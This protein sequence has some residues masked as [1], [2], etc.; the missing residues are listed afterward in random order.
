MEKITQKNTL[1]QLF[2]STH[3]LFL[4]INMIEIWI[5]NLSC[6]I[7]VIWNSIFTF[8]P[9]SVCV[10]RDEGNSSSILNLNE[11]AP[12]CKSNKPEG[13]H[14]ARAV[15]GSVHNWNLTW[16]FSL[17]LMREEK[18]MR[19]RKKKGH[20]IVFDKMEGKMRISKLKQF[21]VCFG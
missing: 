11:N 5:L 16:I 15:C 12:A 19:R 13:C 3:L 18:W 21:P 1:I 20:Q 2:L 4:N 10:S 7:C 8:P 6:T 14:I 9:R 17:D